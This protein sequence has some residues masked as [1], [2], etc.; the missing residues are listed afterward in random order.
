[1]HHKVLTMT[2]KM[3]TTP[4]L[5]DVVLIGAGHAHVGVLRNFGMA[6]VPGVRFTL[7]TRQVDTP[8]SGM[9]PGMI[10]GLY[11]P[12]D[13][14][15]DTGPLARFAGAR[16]YHSEVIGI[17][18]QG[19]RVLC[20]NRPPVPF[21]VLSLN[22]GST[23]SAQ[24]VAGVAERAIPVKPIDSF[25]PRFEAARARIL[26]SGG[27]SRIGVVGAG[28]G[29]V[30]LILALHHRLTRDVRAAGFDPKHTSFAL[31]TSSAELLP[32]L[33]V[34]VR[35]RFAEVMAERGIE[36]HTS[37]R[38]IGVSAEG[39]AIADRQTV[40]LDEIFWTTRAA[41]APWLADTGL[42]LDSQGFVRVGLTLKSVSH[43]DV[44][45]AGDVAAIDGHDLPR[46]GVYAVRSA[47]VL[48]TNIRRLIA[49]GKL[50]RYRPQRDALYLISTGGPHAIGTRNGFMFEGDWA[51]WLKDWIDRRFM[52]KFNKLPEMPQPVTIPMTGIADKQALDDISAIALRCGGCGAK[53]GA[54]VL[55]RALATLVPLSRPTSLLVSRRLMMRP[56]LMWVGPSFRCTLSTISVR[57]SMI[58][59]CLVKSR[60]PMP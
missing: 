28:A 30:E 57:L 53:V 9:L 13:V 46:S 35:K 17:D 24:D 55:S 15:I 25:L 52:A 21:D 59:T 43:P 23:P 60:R 36:L 54:K 18:L 41:A 49:G 33:P 34:K 42:A 58:P 45:A 11:Q 38:V 12:D 14:H 10:A 37:G 31:F 44:F 40:P 16:L 1:M 29:G 22:I 4:V 8:Y 2:M 27:R 32:S 48:A 3:T 50:R 19:K 56:S 47:P 6:P 20:N 51:W 7:I 26:A 5:K 39:V